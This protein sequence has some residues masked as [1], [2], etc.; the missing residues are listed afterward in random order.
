MRPISVEMYDR[1]FITTVLNGSSEEG[2]VAFFTKFVYGWM[3]TQRARKTCQID[4]VNTRNSRVSLS[5]ARALEEATNL[6]FG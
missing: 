6:N 3:F 5:R 1:Q 4:S 2:L